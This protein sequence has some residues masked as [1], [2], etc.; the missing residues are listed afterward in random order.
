MLLNRRLELASGA[1]GVKPHNGPWYQPGW[2]DD[3]AAY[4]PRFVRKWEKP[5]ARRKLELP[6]EA[7]VAGEAIMNGF[8]WIQ[9]EL[10][11]KP[12]TFNH[13]D[14]KPPN[15]FMMPNSVPAFIDWQYTAVG[16]GCQDILFF[17]IEG[18]DIAECRRLVPHTAFS[19]AKLRVH[20]AHLEVRQGAPSYAPFAASDAPDGRVLEGAGQGA[21]SELLKHCAHPSAGSKIH[22]SS[23]RPV[24]WPPNSTTLAPCAVTMT[25]DA[26]SPFSRASRSRTASRMWPTYC[27][28]LR[29]LPVGAHPWREA[30]PELQQRL[31]HL[32]HLRVT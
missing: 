10:S 1:L 18:Y 3:I 24:R 12:H 31:A 21:D 26:T 29:A 14:V 15:M 11:K 30:L 4:W 8:A 23:E 32:L 5:D 7:F 20:S 19:C 25:S 22:I 13:G 28:A 2:G 6:P 9:D 16:K 17:L 27:S